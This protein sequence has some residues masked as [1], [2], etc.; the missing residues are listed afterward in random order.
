MQI[1]TV[2]TAITSPLFLKIN[3]VAL[4]TLFFFVVYTDDSA[5][6]DCSGLDWTTLDL[7][8]FPCLKAV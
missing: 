3:D 4:L 2:Y 8:Q 6:Q 7:V 5:A 1:S